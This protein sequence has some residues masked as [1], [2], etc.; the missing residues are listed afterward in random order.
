MEKPTSKR[1]EREREARREAILDAA[2]EVFSQKS[3]YE[4][5]LDE[6][7]SAAELAKGTL[8]NYFKDKQD[9]FL[10]LILTGSQQF[11]GR[12][13]AAIDAG[14]PLHK[15]LSRLLRTSI[16]LMRQHQYMFRMV[17]TDGAHLPEKLRS[18]TMDS[19]H[20]E[21]DVAASN[22]SQAFLRMPETKN[23][24]AAERI[25]GAYLFMAGVRSLHF[26]FMMNSD[27]TVLD[28][29]IENYSRL[30]CRALTVEKSE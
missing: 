5:T 14:G 12:Q 1:K 19:W 16:E 26:R 9:I 3:F 4:A 25:S 10:S 27:D 21:M 2:A 13:Q 11:V 24:S 22:L 28:G 30:L 8:Y 17:I 7:A 23:L 6:I 15:V 29:E 18:D 20:R